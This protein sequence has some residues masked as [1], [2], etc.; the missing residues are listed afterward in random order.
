MHAPVGY[1]AL[2][3]SSRSAAR[4]PFDG[5]VANNATLVEKLLDGVMV[6]LGLSGE[7]RIDH[8]VVMTEPPCQPNGVRAQLTELMFEAYEVPSV[9]FGVD[10]LF[11]YLYNGHERSGGEMGYARKSGIVVSCGYNATHVLPVHAG[12]YAPAGTKRINVGGHHMTNGL[13]HRL[14]LRHSDYSSLFSYPR[15]EAL[16]HDAC[17][18]SEDFDAEL[19]RIRDDISVYDSTSKIV[20]IPAP[21][22]GGSKVALSAEDQEKAK[23]L[24]IERGKRLSDMMKERNR[25]KAEA[26]GTAGKVKEEEPVAIS[27]EDS[28][29]LFAAKTALRQMER[30]TEVLQ[31]DEDLYYLA[32]AAAGFDTEQRFKEEEESRV[33]AVEDARAALD[34][35]K[36]EFVDMMWLK[37]NAEDELVIVPDAELSAAGLK[38]KRR[39]V[40]MRGAA[41]ARLRIKKEKEAAAESKRLLEEAA[42]KERADDPEKYLAKLCGE[43]LQVSEKVKR[44]KAA[45]E[46]GSDRRSLANRQRMRLLAQHAGAQEE[47]VEEV[48]GGKGGGKRRG[49]GSKKSKS[50]DD[51]G[52]NDSDWDVYRDMRV[53]DD[54]GEEESENDSENDR[55]A[56]VRLRS[57]ISEMAPDDEDPT[58]VRPVGSALLYVPHPFP[59]EVPVV[60]ERIGTPEALFQPTLLGLEQCGLIEA[61]EMVANWPGYSGPTDRRSIVSEVF[62]SGGVANTRGMKERIARELRARFPTAWGDD[63]AAGVRRAKDP[64][65]DAWRGA[66]LF[67]DRGGESFKK[68]CIS[69]RDYEE[70]G[71]DYIAEHGMGNMYVPSVVLDPAES[72]RR[73]KMHSYRRSS[74][75]VMR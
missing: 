65:L 50:A 15:M 45:K 68:A 29:P 26:A 20:G 31:Q 4:S 40:M 5:G 25:A 42:A 64:S 13:S 3:G 48:K 47:V 52:R 27:E 73:K 23:L 22:V 18:V 55:E 56:L 61:I 72:E 44:R 66:Q 8:S 53:R 71:A 19:A 32:R 33:Q 6:R 24:R 59:N 7:E 39:L 63:I 67:A 60:I 35:A 14:Q 62:L 36:V 41:E 54:V 49:P 30:I 38:R 9:C 69:K 10:A 37:K 46:A 58:L 70:N 51:F 12:R 28:A 2:A 11:S 17:Y 1:A 74:N 75:S 21:D 34:D 16:K 57:E 43:R